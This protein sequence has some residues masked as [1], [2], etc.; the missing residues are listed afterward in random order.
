VRAGSLHSE[1]GATQG[2]CVCFVV[3]RPS[4]PGAQVVAGAEDAACTPRC[5]F[6]SE[7]RAAFHPLVMRPSLA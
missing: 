5:R 2:E 7:H 3:H 4:V 1:Q 6:Y